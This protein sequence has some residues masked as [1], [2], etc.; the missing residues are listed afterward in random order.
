M[1]NWPSAATMSRILQSSSS[2]PSIEL[3]F[4]QRR[5]VRDIERVGIW[6]GKVSQRPTASWSMTVER[7][8]DQ[9]LDDPLLMPFEVL[10]ETN[11]VHAVDSLGRSPC[12]APQ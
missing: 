3:Q 9:Q 5:D 1:M 2:S 11:V 7:V 4:G 12:T 10:A 6:I 8:V